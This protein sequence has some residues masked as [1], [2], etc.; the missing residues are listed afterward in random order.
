MLELRESIEPF[1]SREVGLFYVISMRL[2][3][4]RGLR[5]FSWVW[6]GFKSKKSSVGLRTV[7]PHLV[8]GVFPASIYDLQFFLEPTIFAM[9][10]DFQWF[11]YKDLS[12]EVRKLSALH[13]QILK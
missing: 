2:P 9:S 3:L 10:C 5:L 13:I 4:V 1:F 6:E 12:N 11:Q 8:H 7:V